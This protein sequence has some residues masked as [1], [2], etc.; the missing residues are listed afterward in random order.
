M[1][2][3]VTMQQTRRVALLLGSCFIFLAMPKAAGRAS[4]S[5]GRVVW[6]SRSQ[7]AWNRRHI[8]FTG[9][10]REASFVKRWRTLPLDNFVYTHSEDTTH[11]LCRVA[12]MLRG[13]GEKRKNKGKASYSKSGANTSSKIKASISHS[14]DDDESDYEEVGD[15]DDDTDDD[16]WDSINFGDEGDEASMADFEGEDTLMRR[17]KSAVKRTPPIT[18]GFLSLSIAVTF[19]SMLLNGN[20]FPA[21]L[22][23]DWPKVLS[24]LQLWR[25]FSA[26]LYFG[27]FDI[28][29]LLTIQFVW[30]YMSQLEKVHHKEPEQFV[31]MW[32]T[33]ALFLL[34]AFW[35]SSIP[36]A[37]LGHNLSCYLVYV[38]ARTYEGHE[39]NFMELFTMRS[40]LMPWFLALQT[41][42]L[43]G[44]FPLM[45][46]V[47]IAVGHIYY[48]LYSAKMLPVPGFLVNFFRENE[49]LRKRYEAVADD[50]GI[51]DDNN[52]AQ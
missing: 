18:Q 34:V 19:L 46:L 28:S 40:E 45:D 16:D 39:I 6:N 35:M 29:F 26:F 31:V 17:I 48:V 52:D 9:T 32:L 14:S 23:L 33:G 2:F 1:K 24:G 3:R 4:G 43:E 47:G 21:A 13:G 38:W 25:M 8:S 27:P 30:Q 15:D 7:E 5:D 36:T 22:L 10:F 49:F 41:F 37:N 50:F 11:T 51:E 12:M 20:K 44:E 42:L